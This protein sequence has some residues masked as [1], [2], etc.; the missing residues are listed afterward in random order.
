MYCSI[1]ATVL[2]CCC[3]HCLHVRQAT[4]K[5]P[6]WANRRGPVCFCLA[7]FRHTLL[8]RYNRYLLGFHDVAKVNKN[9]N[10]HLSPHSCR[11]LNSF[12]L[13]G[14]RWMIDCMKQIQRTKDR[15]K[16]LKAQEQSKSIERLSPFSIYNY[17]IIVKWPFPRYLIYFNFWRLLRWLSSF[18]AFYS[19]HLG[20]S[21]SKLVSSH[22]PK[23]SV[24]TTM[25]SFIP[26]C[27]P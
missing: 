10:S 19:D 3:L 25:F 11:C 2:T 16:I 24:N 26:G 20:E 8:F 23:Q 15:V 21:W 22:R 4:A 13:C 7:D 6:Y 5:K 27:V 18:N 1:K 9:Q 12:S 14:C 17:H